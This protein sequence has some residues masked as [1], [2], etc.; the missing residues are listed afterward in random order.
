MTDAVQAAIVATL[1]TITDIGQVFDHEPYHRQA[2]ELTARY[3]LN[4]RIRGW[5]VL[6]DSLVEVPGTLGTLGAFQNVER[7]NWR[8]LGFWEV[9][10][11]GQSALEF[12]A[13]LDSIRD[14]FRVFRDLGIA[15]LTTTTDDRAGIEIIDTGLAQFAGAICHAT[16]LGLT[17]ERYI[18]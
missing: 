8:I 3:L 14:K 16:V 2:Q 5:A 4:G 7:V 13:M 18:Q 1:K 6:R 15:G 10:E 12:N 9:S 11:G 17:T